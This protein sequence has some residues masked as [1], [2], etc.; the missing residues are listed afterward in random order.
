MSSIMLGILTC[1]LVRISMIIVMSKQSILQLYCSWRF[2]K[3]NKLSCDA[4]RFHFKNV[5]RFQHGHGGI[6]LHVGL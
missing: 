2:V 5:A 6:Y 3:V 4:R 1:E